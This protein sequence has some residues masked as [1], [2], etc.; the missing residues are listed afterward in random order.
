MD[1]PAAR[2]LLTE[3]TD[4]IRGRTIGEF[5]HLAHLEIRDDPA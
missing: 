4:M 1:R 2:Q 3:H 5:L